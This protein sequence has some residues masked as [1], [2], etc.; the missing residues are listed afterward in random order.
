MV[1]PRSLLLFISLLYTNGVGSA[2]IGVRR[3][4]MGLSGIRRQTERFTRQFVALVLIGV[5]L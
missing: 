4:G 1:A 3:A 5:D 2:T